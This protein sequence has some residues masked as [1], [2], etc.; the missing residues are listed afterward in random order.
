M[1]PSALSSLPLVPTHPCIT[2]FEPAAARQPILSRVLS[3][4]ATG[5]AR[6]AALRGDAS[7]GEDAVL[8]TLKGSV[9]VENSRGE[10]INMHA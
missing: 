4:T 8:Y 6:V 1:R 2:A 5:R 3:T 9:A 10:T 7:A